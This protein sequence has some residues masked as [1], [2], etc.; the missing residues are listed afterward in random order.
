[1][2]QPEPI[3]TTID[4]IPGHTIVEIFGT[5]SGIGMA[6][7][8]ND[9]S[10][11]LDELADTPALAFDSAIEGLMRGAQDLGANAVIG[12]GESTVP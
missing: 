6:T 1:M 8:S 2:T 5:I 3:I 10:Q 11:T 7:P 12:V 9:P 4:N